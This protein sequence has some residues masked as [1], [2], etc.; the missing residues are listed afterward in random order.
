MLHC[1]SGEKHEK[2][3]EES[4][5]IFC[6]GI[7]LSL[8]AAMAETDDQQIDAKSHKPEC[9]NDEQRSSGETH[10]LCKKTKHLDGEKN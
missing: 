3:E 5:G 7:M 2:T 1:S 9:G 8:A 10:G 6:V 4:I